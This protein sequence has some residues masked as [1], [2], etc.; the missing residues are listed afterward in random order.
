[1]QILIADP[2]IYMLNSATEQH[3]SWDFLRWVIVVIGSIDEV[4]LL[5]EGHFAVVMDLPG[6]LRR[7]VGA[8]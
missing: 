5:A 8:T 7:E 2:A 6:V 3:F 4:T 1:M